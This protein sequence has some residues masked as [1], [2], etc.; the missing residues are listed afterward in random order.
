MF[1]TTTCQ[2]IPMLHLTDTDRMHVLRKRAIHRLVSRV[3]NGDRGDIFFALAKDELSEM[4]ERFGETKFVTD[5]KEIMA[6][7]K[8]EVSRLVIAR[9]DRMDGLRDSSPFM[10]VYGFDLGVKSHI[11]LSQPEVRSRL[12][13]LSKNLVTM[14]P[15]HLE[16]LEWPTPTPQ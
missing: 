2:E 16:V 14:R 1:H 4:E 6:L 3:L 9:N 5:W 12:W 13:K 10:R 8:D 15:R 7:D 11:D